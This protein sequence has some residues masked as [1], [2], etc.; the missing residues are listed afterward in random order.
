VEELVRVI[1][2]QATDTIETR[3]INDPMPLRQTHLQPGDFIWFDDHNTPEMPQLVP[4]FVYPVT[5]TTL[6]L[7]TTQPGAIARDQTKRIQINVSDTGPEHYLWMWSKASG[8]PMIRASMNV[9][10]V[11]RNGLPN[12]DF[13]YYR[14]YFATPLP[15]ALYATFATG[16]MSEVAPG[17][18]QSE[19]YAACLSYDKGAPTANYVDV[20]THDKE[21]EPRDAGYINVM[22][23]Q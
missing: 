13:G 22:V 23:V 5:S 7:Y 9:S 4:I 6:E 20:S 17:H 14:V 12:K 15:S 21:G 18:G 2:N 1:F 8:D 3:E 10:G 11:M 16:S 19:G